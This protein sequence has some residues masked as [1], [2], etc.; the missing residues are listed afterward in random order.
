MKR[1]EQKK[2]MSYIWIITDVIILICAV[3]LLLEGGTFN[4]ILSIIGIL[5]VIV[6]FFLYKTG[7]LPKF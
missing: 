1:K 4:I 7:K 2:I 5:L 6:E 3:L